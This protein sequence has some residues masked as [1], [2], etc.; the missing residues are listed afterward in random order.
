MQCVG[1]GHTEQTNDK[2]KAG[3]VSVTE[4]VATNKGGAYA[5]WFGRGQGR[6]G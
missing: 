1:T 3:G 2:G 6:Q 5:P 4:A